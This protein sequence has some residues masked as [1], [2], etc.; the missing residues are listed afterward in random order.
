M[1]LCAL[2]LAGMSGAAWAG[3]AKLTEQDKQISAQDYEAMIRARFPGID[4]PL[5]TTTGLDLAPPVCDHDHKRL[6]YA[7]LL[8]ADTV[9]QQV[10]LDGA[11]NDVALVSEALLA[12]G[13]ATKNI[14]LLSGADATR[15]NLAGAARNLLPRIACGDTLLLHFSGN[16]LQSDAIAPNLLRAGTAN[17][18]ETQTLTAFIAANAQSPEPLKAIARGGPYM[19]LEGD[20]PQ[21]IGLVSPAALSELVTLFRNRRADVV[22]ALDTN[23]AAGFRVQQNQLEVDRARLW[24]SQTQ[25]AEKAEPGASGPTTLS[26]NRGDLAT[27]YAAGD[28]QNTFELALPPDDPEKKIY[29]LFTY[30]LAIALQTAKNLELA[31]LFRAIEDMRFAKRAGPG[32]WQPTPPAHRFEATSGDMVVIAEEKPAQATR[33][34][35]RLLSP[36]P[37]RD[38]T[39]PTE[40]IL[41]IKGRVEWPAKVGVVLVNNIEADYFLATG[42]FGHEVALAPGLNR[43]EI[44]A[45]TQDG[46]MHQRSIELVYQ[47]DAA[48]LAGSGN[49]YA[50]IIANQNY[51]PASGVASLQTPLA[52]AAA[53]AEIL[54]TKYGFQ[55]RVTLPSGEAMSLRLYDQP[56]SLVELVLEDLSLIAGEDDM[57]LVYYAGHGT[58]EQVTAS[59]Y[60][61]PVDARAGRY[62]TFISADDITKAVQR[63][64]ARNVLVISDSCYSG[65]LTRGD[66]AADPIPEIGRRKMLMRLAK[67][68]SRILITSGG[69]EP[70]SDLGGDG[71]SV[72]AR[73]LLTGLSEYDAPAFAARELFERYIWQRVLGG[74]DQEPQYRV[75]PNSGHEEGDVVFARID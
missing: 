52:D 55:T 6:T 51:T 68:R 16:A 14:I 43:I 67:G 5:F 17:A 72:F 26:V 25:A 75:I 71:H 40:P 62:S 22:L 63:L 3:I 12:R 13:V 73:A 37:T 2:L 4:A 41:E 10:W 44:V 39:G 47:G 21:T 60:W 20:K 27:L 69:N 70:V 23:Y 29:G 46:Q 34:S 38:G 58:Y 56:G 65:A 33:D 24:V 8:A 19:I 59:A 18:A 31:T 1:M 54:E 7:I 61:V 53:L 74:S 49:R 48:A 9:A 32:K 36:K 35:I 64:Q 28:H 42:E 66:A 45:R 15:A 50:V 30:K 57:V 11:R